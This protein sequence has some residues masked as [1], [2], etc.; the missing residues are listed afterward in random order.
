MRLSR[1][2]AFSLVKGSFFSEFAP[3]PSPPLRG[4]AI[5]T[6]PQPPLKGSAAKTTNSLPPLKGEG[7]REAVEGLSKSAQGYERN[8]SVSGYAAASSPFRGALGELPS[9]W[10]PLHKG[11][12]GFS[13]PVRFFDKP[14]RRSLCSAGVLL[15]PC[16]AALFMSGIPRASRE[17]RARRWRN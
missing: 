17:R 6:N 7:D 10:L 12:G 4:A 9:P 5:T 1:R 16:G 13:A 11:A 14:N 2:M 3:H 8:P 15:S